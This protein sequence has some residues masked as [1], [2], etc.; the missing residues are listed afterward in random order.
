MLSRRI[1]TAFDYPLFG[2]TLILALIGAIG[3]YSV[4]A[5]H[6]L[7]TN[8]LIRLVLGIAVCLVIIIPDY[9]VL[10]EYAFVFYVA[11]V[12]VL[13]AVLLLGSEING[14]RSWI[15]IPGFSFQPSE[16]V[17]IVLV[18]AAARYLSEIDEPFL[19]TRNIL[20]L[21][22]L[23]LVPMGLVVLQ[24]DLGTALVYGPIALGM[25]I[26]AGLRIKVL[27]CLLFALLLVAPI[28]W[29]VL[30]DY[31]RERLLVT[32]DP[33]R[34]PQGVGYQAR[35]SQIAIGS[36]GLLGKGIGKGSQSQLGFVPE[37][38]T[39][40]IF[41]VFAEETG[42]VGSGSVLILFFLLLARLVA[43][44]ESA[45]DRLGILI[46]SGVVSLLAAHLVINIGMTLG[47][48]P[49]I[50]IPLPLLSYG[51]SFLLTTF[52]AIGLALNI[53]FRRFVHA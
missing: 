34:D 32:V 4:S 36:G 33:S 17:K 22:V 45:R 8:Q 11:S 20:F 47:V 21:G 3:I 39:D 14:S 16:L 35:Q 13:I 23:T 51:G 29:M 12:A 9:R 5:G 48:L 25:M 26:V 42:L 43:I 2:L 40:F 37:S 6:G 19:S 18:L 46:I 27:L 31:Q 10:S 44:A 52:L 38:H 28:G 50:G 1:A 41:S 53:S 15:T 30:K 24:G 49:A 7:F